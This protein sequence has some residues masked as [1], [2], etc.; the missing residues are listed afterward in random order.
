MKRAVFLDRDG[1]INKE[2]HL[3]NSVSQL[4]ILPGAAKAIKK[5]NQLGFLVI[6]ITNQGVIARGLATEKEIDYI[7]GVLIERLNR[8]RAKIDAIYYCPHHPKGRI[9]KYR[10]RC[11]CRKPNIGLLTRAVKD[12]K[13]NLKKSFFVGDR[14]ADILAGQRASL[15]TILLRTGYGGKDNL[16]KIKP[17]WVAKNL[18]EAAKIINNYSKD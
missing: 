15:T 17:N 14:T 13:I 2:V 9:K 11:R 16:Y 5:F 8:G 7:H 4:R 3:L 12:L 10:F 18:S 1:T 6:I